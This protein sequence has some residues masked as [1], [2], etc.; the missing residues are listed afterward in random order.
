MNKSLS[1]FGLLM[2]YRMQLKLILK[3][4]KK[5]VKNHHKNKELRPIPN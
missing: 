4:Q 2:K 5:R 3:P 1:M